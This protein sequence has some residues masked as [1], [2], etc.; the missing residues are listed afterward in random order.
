[1]FAGL[2]SIPITSQAARFE[3]NNCVPDIAKSLA[4][5]STTK[6]FDTEIKVENNFPKQFFRGNVNT[7]F[8]LDNHFQGILRLRDPNYMVISGGVHRAK[9]GQLLIADLNSKASTTSD[10]LE[11]DNQLISRIDFPDHTHWHAGGLARLGDIVAVPLEKKTG[12]SRIVFLDFSNPTSPKLIPV[13]I[14]REQAN[15]GA[16]AL[17]KLP[18]EHF[19]L[20]VYTPG[21][22]D[23]Y[24]SKTLLL[25]D[26]FSD[27]PNASMAANE[28]GLV[29]GGEGVSL[30]RQCDGKLF[31]LNFNNAG[32]L[33]P[34]LNGPNRIRAFSIEGMQGMPGDAIS[35]NFEQQY[36]FDCNGIC[37]FAASGS[38]FVGEDH[39]VRI[40]STGFFRT[41]AGSSIPIA[42]YYEP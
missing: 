27:T 14:D 33:P 18:N 28:S 22:L 30:V 29:I 20:A 3:E 25:E 16:I 26:G 38:V 31:Y 40:Y 17:E 23:F 39:K 37:N 32:L 36:S 24:Y 35:L 11:S 4:Y 8:G 19:V 41:H 21:E 7:R 9:T 10:T 34:L 5:L 15:A 13:E 2:S 6:P 12:G 1:M 42:E